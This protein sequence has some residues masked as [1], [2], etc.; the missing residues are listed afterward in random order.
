MG[1]HGVAGNTGGA[2]ITAQCPEQTDSGLQVLQSHLQQGVF[3]LVL[4]TL[5]NQ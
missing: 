3:G 4:G 1:W 2:K 5:N